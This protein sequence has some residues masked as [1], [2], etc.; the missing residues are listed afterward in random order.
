[1]SNPAWGW[2][3]SSGGAS[4]PAGPS[5]GGDAKVVVVC[6]NGWAIW[7][8][9]GGLMGLTDFL[10]SPLSNISFFTGG[11]GG[12]ILVAD[13]AAAGSGGRVLAPSEPFPIVRQNM[14]ANRAPRGSGARA[15]RNRILFD[16]LAVM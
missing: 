1:M 16:L 7:T 13:L 10:G 15:L 8:G 12:G 5:A 9:F 11:D 3:P 14:E 4:P 2:V 6:C